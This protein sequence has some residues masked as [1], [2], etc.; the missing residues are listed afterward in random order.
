MTSIAKRSMFSLR[1]PLSVSIGLALALVIVLLSLLSSY[2]APFDPM[3][4]ASGPRLAAPSAAHLFGTDEFGRDLFSR[5]LLGGRLSLGIGLSAVVSGLVIGGLI[6]LIAAFGGRVVEALLLRLIDVLYSFPDTLIALALVAF[7]GPGIENATLAIAISLVP[8]YARVAYGLAAAERAKPYIEAA[9]L[10]GTRSARLVR[11]H[12]MPNIVQSLIVM[13]TLGFSSAI[14][15]AAG[16]SFLG[17]GVQPPSPEW[18]AILAS[19][20]NYIT[21]A[22]W[23]LI[24]PGLAICLTVLSFNLIGDSLRDLIDPRRKARP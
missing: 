20:R 14:L 7:L 3:R 11:V 4:M 24:F 19:G 16:L 12:V 18:G 22:P 5:V 10:A 23:I 6:G 2:I 13:A 8:F 17:L 1:L 15:S 9:R 21:K